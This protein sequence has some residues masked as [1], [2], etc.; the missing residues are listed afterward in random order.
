MSTGCNLTELGKVTLQDMNFKR[1]KVLSRSQKK[2]IFI[3][4]GHHIE[5]HVHANVMAD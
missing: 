3:I 2:N 1:A 4:K 5:S